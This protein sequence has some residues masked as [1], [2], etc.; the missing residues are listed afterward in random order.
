MLLFAGHSAK[1]IQRQGNA[2]LEH[3]RQWGVMNKL[4]FAVHKTKAMLV[5]KKLKYDTPL[6]RMGGVD[7]AMSKE[8]K[9]LGVTI[10]NGLTFASHVNNVSK[11]ALAVYKQLAHAAKTSWG[12]HSEIIKTIYIA[13]VEPIITYASCAWAYATEKLYIQ[14]KLNSV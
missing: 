9:I 1:E 14:Q 2:A 8:I 11:K 12:L 6:L 10:D 13:T 3:V 7:I 4:K 5:T